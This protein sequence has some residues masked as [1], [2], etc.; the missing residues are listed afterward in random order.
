MDN[1]NTEK[2]EGFVRVTNLPEVHKLV[3]PHYDEDRE[4]AN[5]LPKLT[6][7]RK[8]ATEL[9]NLVIT[10]FDYYIEACKKYFY[11]IS[12]FGDRQSLL[13]SY[14]DFE[15]ISI[16][17]MPVKAILKNKKIKIYVDGHFVVGR[18]YNNMYDGT[19][20][21]GPEYNMIFA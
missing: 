7:F 3:A 9:L 5:E 20:S 19:P 13:P 16:K 2:D 18:E 4:K 8:N 15:Y 10:K 21:M 17:M 11:T 1:N 6:V 14:C 12:L